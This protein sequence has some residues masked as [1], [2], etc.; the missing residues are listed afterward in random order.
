MTQLAASSCQPRSVLLPILLSLTLVFSATASAAAQSVTEA[1][2]RTSG[3]STEVDQN[4][5]QALKKL[6]F[7]GAAVADPNLLE[8]ALAPLQERAALL[9]AED[10]K[11]LRYGQIR[12]LL[13][14]ADAAGLAQ[15]D[16]W[17]RQLMA[18]QQERAFVRLIWL[19]RLE[20]LALAM[21]LQLQPDLLAFVLIDLV[22]SMADSPIDP[23]GP[24]HDAV[25]VAR[26]A[27]ASHLLAADQ[28]AEALDLLQPVT[29][30]S[31][32]FGAV[33]RLAGWAEEQLIP[34]SSIADIQMDFR[35]WLASTGL[36]N[37]VQPLEQ[38][39]ALPLRALE[40]R[41]LQIR[42]LL[43]AGASAA[44][45][46]WA[47]RWYDDFAQHQQA[48]SRWQNPKVLAGLY[49]SWQR[50][51]TLP[52]SHQVDEGVRQFLDCGATR[53]GYCHPLAI[54]Y[55]WDAFG[56]DQVRSSWVSLKEVQKLDERLRLME[57]T[58]D[59]IP[60]PGGQQSDNAEAWRGRVAW[61][62]DSVR[63]QRHVAV[64]QMHW[65]IVA[66]LEDHSQRLGYYASGFRYRLLQLASQE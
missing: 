40:S 27:V 58:A 55:L 15:V 7:S 14:H 62:E 66:D 63:F 12:Y 24:L 47:R 50:Q 31:A 13:L 60:Q 20:W 51:V 35:H 57:L 4:L 9:S 38:Q 48:I 26:F 2:A 29:P 30:D 52:D 33:I 45:G 23:R 42:L 49:E 46:E 54:R 59:G 53:L 18:E 22:D 6:L 39:A 16:E 17:L 11:W 10:L 25:D 36:V 5:V 19:A 28:P 64:R 32:V 21:E 37:R 61:L 8:E 65:S 41:R 3:S 44:A 56:S 34:K 1:T 43:A